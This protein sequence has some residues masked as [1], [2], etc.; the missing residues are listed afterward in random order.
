MPF[1][2]GK[3]IKVSMI[4]EALVRIKFKVLALGP[5]IQCYI[6]CPKFHSALRAKKEM[7]ARPILDS[8]GF[9]TD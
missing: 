3:A 8:R 5:E 9:S 2:K 6:T 1:S 4:Y 7:M